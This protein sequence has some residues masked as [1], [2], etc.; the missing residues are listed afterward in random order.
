MDI[1]NT[2]REHKLVI[3]SIFVFVLTGFLSQG[4]MHPDEHYQILELLNIKFSSPYQDSSILNWDFH[5]KM[6][7]WFQPFFYYLTFI[8]FKNFNPFLL[9]ALIRVFNGLLALFALVCL[10]RNLSPAHWKKVTFIMTC[11][12]FIPYL[13]VR[14]S[15]ESLATSLFII[16]YCLI[17]KKKFHLSAALLGV[18]FLVRFQMAVIIA[19]L[20][21]FFLI[22]KKI[23]LK[24]FLEMLLIIF[25]AIGL[26]VLVD[27]WGYGTW[28]LSFYNYLYHNLVEGRSKE[29]GV[30][31]VYY[32]M[33]K[34]LIKGIPLLSIPILIAFFKSSIKKDHKAL[35]YSIFAFIIINSFISHK[36]VRFLTPVYIIMTTFSV[37]EICSRK[38]WS[39]YIPIYVLINLIV[40]MK[41]SLTPAHSRIKLYREIYD[42]KLDKV[43]TIKKEN[44][45]SFTLP[46][47]M[48]NKIEVLEESPQNIED[49]YVLL[50]T[51]YKEFLKVSKR[52]NCNLFFSQYPTW[53]KHINV[54]NWLSRSSFFSAWR[55]SKKR[56]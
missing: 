31:P 40:M 14:T 19:P 29:F 36:E 2:I 52:K 43:Y 25:T 46:F 12:W 53:I 9:A 11:T 16:S 13:M 21:I 42:R 15:S 24:I 20:M 6:R 1:S 35:I 51:D 32:F 4:F 30:E 28:T 44:K 27:Y 48:K 45:F 55:C 7:S 10:V 54:T 33:V 18:V 17:L 3:A 5:L 8:P 41:T 38:K 22:N 39:K 47:Y 49:N 34:P 26:G 37:V 23:N 56:L 50:A